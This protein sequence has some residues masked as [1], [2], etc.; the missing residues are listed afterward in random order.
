MPVRDKAVVRVAQQL[1]GIQDWDGRTGECK[2]MPTE[3][4]YG[5]VEMVDSLFVRIAEMVDWNRVLLEAQGRHLTLEHDENRGYDDT[6]CGECVF[7]ALLSRDQ[8]GTQRGRWN[9]V[10]DASEREVAK[11]ITRGSHTDPNYQEETVAL[12]KAM[13]Y[14]GKRWRGELDDGG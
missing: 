13:M 1:T 14:D 4:F 2:S 11:P 10:G 8:G 7:E 6:P 3:D 9:Y 12:A 5:V